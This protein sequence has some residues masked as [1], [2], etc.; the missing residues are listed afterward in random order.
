MLDTEKAVGVSWVSV[1][2]R[3]PFDGHTC[4]LLCRNSKSNDLS[5]AIGC[6][7]SWRWLTARGLVCISCTKLYSQSEALSVELCGNAHSHRKVGR[8]PWHMN[9]LKSRPKP[10][11]NH[12]LQLIDILL[13]QDPTP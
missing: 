9:S 6:P 8:L 4:A 11:S 13:D 2:D 1:I 7:A 12:S 5:R 10:P 3:L